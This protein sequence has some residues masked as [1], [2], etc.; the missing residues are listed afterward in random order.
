MKLDYE[1]DEDGAEINY[2]VT[3]LSTNTCINAN[4]YFLTHYLTLARVMMI[5][6]K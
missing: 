5:I 6:I 4:F 2:K 1:D 3:S